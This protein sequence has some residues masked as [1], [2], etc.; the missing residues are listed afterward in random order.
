MNNK[1]IL[2]AKLR[3]AAALFSFILFLISFVCLL[4]ANAKEKTDAGIHM[5]NYTSNSAVFDQNEW[6]VDDSMLSEGAK[7]CVFLYG[8]VKP[9]SKG[10]YEMHIVYS[11]ETENR[12]SISA[13]RFT[14][15][16]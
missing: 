4:A 14:D 12:I 2:N 11:A 10:S 3:K 9:L 8:P 15:N 6:Y 16:S 5:E 13:A 7:D 1:Q